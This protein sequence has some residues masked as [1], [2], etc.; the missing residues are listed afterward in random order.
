MEL[1]LKLQFI[2]CM[3]ETIIPSITLSFKLKDHLDSFELLEG[4]FSNSNKSLAVSHQN[5]SHILEYAS[6]QNKSVIVVGS[7]IIEGCVDRVTTSK[8]LLETTDLQEAIK[9]LNGEFL[10]I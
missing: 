3:H 7:P 6:E 10:L 4:V 5:M 8:I 9:S 1:L 2:G